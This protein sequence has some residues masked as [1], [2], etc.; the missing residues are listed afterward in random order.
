ME[1]R[2]VPQDEVTL[3]GVN[4]RLVRNPRCASTVAQAA[5][6]SIDCWCCCYCIVLYCIVLCGIALHCT[7]INGMAVSGGVVDGPCCSHDSFDHPWMVVV[8]HNKLPSRS[9][10]VVHKDATVTVVPCIPVSRVYPLS[11]PITNRGALCVLRG[12]SL[13]PA[14][15]IPRAVGGAAARPGHRFVRDSRGGV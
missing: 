1:N 9:E 10:A 8:S 5:S 12:D 2:A 14:T 4:A 6:S 7:L 3:T 15:T 11:K 13:T